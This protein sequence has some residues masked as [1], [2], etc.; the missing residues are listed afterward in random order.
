M[1][2]ISPPPFPTSLNRPAN[3]ATPGQPE[4]D[5]T[6]IGN[7]RV[8]VQVGLARRANSFN[9]YKKIIGT[10][11]GPIKVLNTD[12]DQHVLESLPAGQTVEITVTGVN[13][14]DEGQPSEPVSVVVT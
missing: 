11:P 10:D 7:G 6:A 1:C 8:L 12:N 3:P 4:I 13:D 5:A 9:Y 14:A 2:N